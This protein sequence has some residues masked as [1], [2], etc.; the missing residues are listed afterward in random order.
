MTSYQSSTD[1]SASG[2]FRASSSAE[3]LA[4]VGEPARRNAAVEEAVY[5]LK[6]SVRDLKSGDTSREDPSSYLAFYGY[7]VSDAIS[8]CILCVQ[9]D[10]ES[11]GESSLGFSDAAP[12][13]GDGIIIAGP[14]RY[15]NC[16]R[17]ESTSLKAS[18]SPRL[19]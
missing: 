3:G 4:I 6:S 16:P 2:I 18:P 5:A 7:A 1:T 11:P 14:D 13:R 9:L 15:I 19:V 10:L 12:I 17:A 8:A